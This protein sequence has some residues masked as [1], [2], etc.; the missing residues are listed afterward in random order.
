MRRLVIAATMMLL[1]AGCTS[2]QPVGEHDLLSRYD[3]AGKDAV[4]IVDH[5]DRLEGAQRPTQLMASVRPDELVLSDDGSEL[6]LPLPEDR[7]YVSVAPYVQQ[8]HECFHHSLTTCQGELT[9]TEVQ[10]TV[11]DSTSGKVLVDELTTTFANG[12]VGLWLP[13]DVAGTVAVTADGRT[14]EIPLTTGDDDP[15]CLTTLQ[16]R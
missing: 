1:L 2:A 6:S 11:T 16:L 10:V 12:F 5:L 13:R 4:E 7:F 15:T 3:L 14:G 9:D 8:T